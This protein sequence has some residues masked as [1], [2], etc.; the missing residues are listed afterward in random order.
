MSKSMSCFS[1]DLFVHSL[2]LFLISPTVLHFL[3][4][5]IFFIAMRQEASRWTLRAVLAFLAPSFLLL[6]LLVP[7]IPAD[8]APVVLSTDIPH[9]AQT[10]GVHVLRHNVTAVPLNP[11]EFRTA[12]SRMHGTP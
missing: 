7:S 11:A 1:S 10:T 9:A 6:L 8:A 2:L 4:F 12:G 5:H 3:F